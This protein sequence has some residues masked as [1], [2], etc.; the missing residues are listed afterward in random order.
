MNKKK[1]QK[2]NFKR[3]NWFS[4]RE[5]CKNEITLDILNSQQEDIDIF[6]SKLIEIATKNIPKT[7]PF[8]N[9]CSKPWFDEECKAAKRER[10]KANRLNKKY[11]CLDNAIKVKV[12]NAKARRI[13]NYKKDNH[14]K[15]TS[16]Q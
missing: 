7:S 4:F 8:N 9:K 6:T 3:A 10:S 16:L 5:Q 2:W 12:A 13:F 1:R 14:G 11:P 15:T